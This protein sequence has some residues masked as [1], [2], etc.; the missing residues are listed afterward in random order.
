VTLGYVGGV[1]VGAYPIGIVGESFDN[2]DGSS[3][4]SE[5]RRCSP[6]EPVVLERDPHNKYDSNCVKVVSARGVQIG[7]I[8]RGDA[9]ICERLDRSAFLDA[10]IFSI[11]QGQRGMLGVVLCVRTG[12]DEPWLDGEQ[13]NAS[14]PPGCSLLI[15]SFLPLGGACIAGA[16]RAALLS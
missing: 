8:S 12:E 2:D 14:A 9:W 5:I 3:R 6:E 16:V 11:G 10:R 15:A 4:Q 7:N 1:T 13:A